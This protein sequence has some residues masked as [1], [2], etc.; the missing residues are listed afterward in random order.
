VNF[1]PS[2]QPR[3]RSGGVSR[4]VGAAFVVRLSSSIRS[5]GRRAAATAGRARAS[6]RTGA[7]SVARASR[8]RA[9]TRARTRARRRA[10]APAAAIAAA[11]AVV[12]PVAAGGAAANARVR[13]LARNVARTAAVE[14]DRVAAQRAVAGNVTRLAAVEALVGSGAGAAA[15]A[16]RRRSVAANGAVAVGG[17]RRIAGRALRPRRRRTKGGRRRSAVGRATVG[18]AVGRR[19]AART[20]VVRGAVARFGDLDEQLLAGPLAAVEV[21]DGVFGIAFALEFLAKRRKGVV[22][23]EMGK[24]ERKNFFFSPFSSSSSSSCSHHK[25]E[26]G[27]AAHVTQRTESAKLLVDVALREAMAEAADKQAR[28][29]HTTHTTTHSFVRSAH[30]DLRL[31]PSPSSSSHS[32]QQRQT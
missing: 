5:G 19:A 1:R 10:A 30:L 25:C 29:W 17:R 11:S 27:L 13:A 21:A 8:A 28:H 18:R 23:C 3:A 32:P 12:V 6:R 22:E 24:R 15:T 9:R 31:P 14:A 20:A 7:R 2:S 26:T 16:G 4:S